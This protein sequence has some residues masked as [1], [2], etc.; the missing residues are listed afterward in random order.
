MTSREKSFE[1]TLASKESMQIRLGSV[2]Y[3]FV[4]SR[5]RVQYFHALNEI[6]CCVT[7][8]EREQGAEPSLR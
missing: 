1:I 5:L 6:N 7:S 2:A 3:H 4:Q 8:L